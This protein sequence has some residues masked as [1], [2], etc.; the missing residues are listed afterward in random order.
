[1]SLFR[2]YLNVCV[3]TS[4]WDI[5]VLKDSSIQAYTPSNTSTTKIAS[6]NKKKFK[7]SKLFSV[8]VFC[9]FLTHY[10]YFYKKYNIAYIFQKKTKPKYKKSDLYVT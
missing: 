7:K 1:M 2:H 8:F 4:M 5:T 9:V 10:Y 3:P 6:V